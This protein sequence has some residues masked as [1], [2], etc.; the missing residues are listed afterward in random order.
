MSASGDSSDTP[1]ESRLRKLLERSGLPTSLRQVGV[2]EE[3][4]PAL[5]RAALEQ[6]TGT[7][8]PRPLQESA[9]LALY[10]SAY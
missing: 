4:L 8:N 1:I 3:D 5:A 9:A 10:Q 7:F 2:P 6:W